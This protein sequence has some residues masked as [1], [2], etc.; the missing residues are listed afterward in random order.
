MHAEQTSLH[1]TLRSGVIL[2]ATPFINHT[3]PMTV[4]I[5]SEGHVFKALAFQSAWLDAVL[6]GPLVSQIMQF[7]HVDAGEALPLL[8]LSEDNEW[9]EG[10]NHLADA[11]C[12][13]AG[14]V[15]RIRELIEE[16]G[17]RPLRSFVTDVILR[18]DVASR[19][20]TMPASARDHHS[21]P[22]GLAVHSMEVAS[23]I[24]LHSELSDVE[25]DLGVA[26][27]LLHDIGKIWSY[28]DAMLL[29][30]ASLAMGH[31][32]IGLCRLE[33]ELAQLETLWPDGAYVMR[34]L[35]SGNTWARGN[36]SRPTAL[37]QRIK[38]CDHRSCERDRVA[39]NKRPSSRLAWAPKEWESGPKATDGDSR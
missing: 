23:D 9:E 19:F 7:A 18:R 24:S 4:C 3:T 13:V 21:V 35:L 14:T 5:S 20:W 32:L 38:A 16:I 25:H 10:I 6:Q 28:T 8:V 33:P 37:I 22:G 31:E 26:G 17:T 12:P 27:A 39:N 1:F 30:S 34:C 11:L 29:N 36:G 2:S 15:L